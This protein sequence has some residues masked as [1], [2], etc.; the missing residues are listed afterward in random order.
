MLVGVVFIVVASG[1]SW[2]LIASRPRPAARVVAKDGGV[3][4]GASVLRSQWS[5]DQLIRDAVGRA[6]PK[7]DAQRGEVH[8]H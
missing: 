2:G 4:S 6:I 7:E 8:R 3:D 1:C 5:D